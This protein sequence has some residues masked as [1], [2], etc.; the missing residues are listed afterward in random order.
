VTQ[1]LKRYAQASPSELARFQ[2]RGVEITLVP[3]LAKEIGISKSRL[4]KSLRLSPSTLRRRQV[5]G[6]K[7]SKDDSES[8]TRVVKLL[9]L[10][11]DSLA[12][13]REWFQQPNPLLDGNSPLDFAYTEAGGRAVE[14]LLMQI[15]HGSGA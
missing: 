12:N 1:L 5:A 13:P 15:Q 6:A 8:V 14:A 10:A 7:L 9:A 11:Q 3:S 4:Q 2:A